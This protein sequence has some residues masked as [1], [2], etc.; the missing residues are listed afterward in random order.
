MFRKIGINFRCELTLTNGPLNFEEHK[1]NK[2]GI[3]LLKITKLGPT[4]GALENATVLKKNHKY[5]LSL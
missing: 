3:I 2:S 1:K 4:S 5:F